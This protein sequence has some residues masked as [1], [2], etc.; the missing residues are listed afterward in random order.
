MCFSSR[1]PLY[2]G[3]KGRCVLRSFSLTFI[4]TI[5]EVTEAMLAEVGKAAVIHHA[6]IGKSM[7]AFKLYDEREGEMF[8]FFLK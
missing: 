5:Y 6:G 3:N 4:Q 2:S 7:I 8:L 1:E